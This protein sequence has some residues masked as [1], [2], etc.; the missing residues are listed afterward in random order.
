MKTAVIDV[1]NGMRGIYAAGVLDAF[2]EEDVKFDVGIG[3]SAGSGNIGSFAAQQPGRNYRFYIDYAMRSSFMGPG[4]LIRDKSWLNLDYIFNSLSLEYGEDPLNYA[5]VLSNEMEMMLIAND[6]E[7]GNTI[8]FTKWDLLPN[9]HA[10]FKAASAIPA[11]CEP[12][13]AWGYLCYDGALVDPVPVQTALDMGYDQ[14]VLILCKPVTEKRTSEW[15]ERMASRIENDYP[16]AA[17]HL[18]KRAER[19]NQGIDNAVKLQEEGVVHIIAPKNTHRINAFSKDKIRLQKL[20]EDGLK[21][22]RKAID[23][24]S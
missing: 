4:N 10:I 5:N 8:Y 6:A 11:V 3:V 24:L 14:I 21:D 1:S 22:G 7:T 19:Y 18:R 20:Y 17:E 13:R 23:L 12:Q 2:M 9:D 15:D 16:F